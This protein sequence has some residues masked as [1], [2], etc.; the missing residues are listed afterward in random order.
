MLA[1][2]YKCVTY[3]LLSE[4]IRKTIDLYLI[5]SSQNWA[6]KGQKWSALYCKA[7]QTFINYLRYCMLLSSKRQY[8][9]QLSSHY[10]GI[11]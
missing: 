6:K 9:S 4:I 5:G 8:S 3:V 1:R 7:I 2:V 11:C 10:W